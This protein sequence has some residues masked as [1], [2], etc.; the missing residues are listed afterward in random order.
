MLYTD[1][2]EFNWSVD[3][4]G[5]TY[6]DTTLG[7]QVTA[8]ASAH[9]K[10]TAVELISG[11]TVT[12]DVY[13]VS[14]FFCGARVSTG[15]RRFFV[16]LLVDEAGG[17]AWVTR[18][19]NLLVNSPTSD[20]GFYSYYF[21]LFIKAGSSIGA[22]QQCSTGGQT[23]RCGIKLF[24]KPSHPHLVKVGSK[25]ETFGADTS[26]TSGTSFTSGTGEMGSYSASL[27]TTAGNLF[28]W[29][30]GMATSD[31]SITGGHYAMDV[32]CGDATNKKT[33]ISHLT[34]NFDG[35]EGCGKPEFGDEIPY[36]LIAPG[37]EVYVRSATHT[38]PDSDTTACV[39]GVC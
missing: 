9:T 29:Q 23:L 18:I 22:Q 7:V 13:G 10:G 34:L 4:Y 37:A 19:N 32:A 33:C 1:V 31:A 17:T 21:P 39:Y 8:H 2:N 15:T 5:A 26:T 38:T 16:D 20:R 11:A 35:T 27:G 14:L 3:N 28:F 24:G 6:S 30:V 36:R 12:E 25:V